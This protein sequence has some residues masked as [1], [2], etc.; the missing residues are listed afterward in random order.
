MYFVIQLVMPP[1][2][3]FFFTLPGTRGP[4]LLYH[5]F[6]V[7]DTLNTLLLN[8][9]S[10]FILLVLLLIRVVFRWKWTSLVPGSGSLQLSNTP[11]ILL[12]ILKV[13][14]FRSFSV[15]Y[16]YFGTLVFTLIWTES[17]VRR[18]TLPSTTFY[19]YSLSTVKYSLKQETFNHI[20]G[21]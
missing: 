3:Y 21:T 20:R 5:P 13:S 8:S 6:V 16:F 4:L 15:N 19:H 14:V 17:V 7:L 2:S 18:G 10:L 12:L 1:I 11:R 9:Q